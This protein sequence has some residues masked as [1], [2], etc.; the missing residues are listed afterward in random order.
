MKTL[1]TTLLLLVFAIPTAAQSYIG[2]GVGVGRSTS[3][4]DPTPIEFFGVAQKKA[5]PLHFRGLGGIRTQPQLPT[6][7]QEGAQGFQQDGYELFARP[8]IDLTF[9]HVG[10]LK[11]F[12]GIGGDFFYQVFPNE[13]G[14]KDAH[15]HSGLNPLLTLGA[16]Y[17]ALG[18][19]HRTGVTR[20]FQ[21]LKAREF[22]YVTAYKPGAPLIQLQHRGLLNPAYLDGWRLSHEYVKPIKGR[23]S[24]Y[25]AGEGSYYKYKEFPV[26]FFGD[27][28]YERDAVVAFRFGAL[29]K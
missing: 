15:Y 28:Y 7:F 5:G 19:K 2:A 13:P 21:E 16:R 29:Y 1:F 26:K 17:T 14:G 9:L 12:A 11:G 3:D 24:F 22:P 6:L 8:E 10:P 20:V 18:G 27:N 23:L 4:F 25:F